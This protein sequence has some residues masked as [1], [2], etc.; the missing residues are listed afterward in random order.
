V[1]VCLK[2]CDHPH[3]LNVGSGAVGAS[4]KAVSARVEAVA[5]KILVWAIAA[6]IN[7]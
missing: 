4:C 1:K 7:R 3:M 6:H 2:A 5:M